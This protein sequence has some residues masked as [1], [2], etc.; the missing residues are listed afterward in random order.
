MCFCIISFRPSC[1]AHV[2]APGVVFTM[3]ENMRVQGE[4]AE[5]RKLYDNCLE[6]WRK[7]LGEDS[8]EVLFCPILLCSQP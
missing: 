8:E 7:V 2:T 5:S 3:A 6:M 1:V 4:Y